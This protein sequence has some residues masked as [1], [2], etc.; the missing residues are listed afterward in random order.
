[1][2]DPMTP[3]RLAEIRRRYDAATPGPWRYDSGV[4]DTRPDGTDERGKEPLIET[5]YEDGQGNYRRSCIGVLFGMDGE[6]QMDADGLFISES[7]SAI[8][9]LLA[10]VKRLRLENAALREQS[11]KAEARASMEKP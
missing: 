1:M 5:C 9:D 8:R 6:R 11:M 4:T 7:W 2:S 10:E 3:E